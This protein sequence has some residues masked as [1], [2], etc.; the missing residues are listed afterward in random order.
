[1]S[2]AFAPEP[3]GPSRAALLGAGPATAP[4]IPLS[5]DLRLQLR[6]HRKCD[7]RYAPL[8][9]AMCMHDRSVLPR[10]HQDDRGPRDQHRGIHV[11]APDGAYSTVPAWRSREHWVTYAV[12]AAIA[13]HREVLRKLHVSETQLREWAKVKSGYAHQSTGRRCVV[14][15]DTLAAVL[16]V[17]ERH[18]QNINRAAREI[19][20]EVVAL[21]G[22][23]LTRDEKHHCWRSGSRQRGLATESALTVPSVLRL[24]VDSFTPARGRGFS[25]KTSIIRSSPR[26]LAAKQEGAATP[27]HPQERRRRK[28]TARRLASDVVLAVPWLASESP[29]RL[30]PTL[31]RFATAPE[32]WTAPDVVAVIESH[33]IRTGRGAIRA[34]RIRTRPAALLASILRGLDVMADHPGLDPFAPAPQSPTF[35]GA[36][37]DVALDTA[38]PTPVRRESC[39]R[40]ECDHGWIEQPDGRVVRCAECPP[41]AHAT[42]VADPWASAGTV[43]EYGDPLF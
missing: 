34:D 11:A 31:M 36:A 4:V 37:F 29:G 43:D 30:V 42:E 17:S 1:V 9:R 27:P 35:E 39:G 28:K 26:G 20:L 24:V 40:A 32:P 15:P 3:A 25:P 21:N 23:M 12:P 6:I 18:V 41:G 19:G 7:A 16:G 10:W 2:A 38:T 33:A 14:R 22:R 5:A 13:H 8:V